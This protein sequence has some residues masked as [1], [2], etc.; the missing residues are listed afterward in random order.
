MTTETDATVL[1]MQ[2]L[3]GRW[4]VTGDSRATFLSCYLLM[5][6]NMLAAIE[7]D[8]F[9]DPRW[10]HAFVAHFAGYYFAALDGFEQGRS[11]APAVWHVANAAAARPETFAIQNLLLGVNAHI[12]YDLVLAVADVLER[13]WQGLPAPARAER[14]A[15]YCQVNAVISRTVDAVQ[16]QVLEPQSP[17]L[18]LADR[19]CGGL[20]EWL[21][22]RLIADWRDE[23]WERA[24]RLL[25]TTDDAERADLRHATEQAALARARAILLHS[26]QD[27]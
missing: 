24:V 8:E 11:E 7:R 1:R 15:D 2:D 21:I 6:R 5:T 20:D 27:A 25:E 4:T 10:V 9:H 18:A 22:S 14:H 19:L 26:G 13:E 16:E 23:V 17:L 3:V 12:N